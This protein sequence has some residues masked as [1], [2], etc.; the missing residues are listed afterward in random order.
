MKKERKFFTLIE[1][2]VVIAIIAILASMLLP[3]LNQARERA[4]AA[5]CINN[6]KQIT[7]ACII[8]AQDYNGVMT[9][10]HPRNNVYWSNEM[11]DYKYLPASNVFL[12]PNQKYK[13]PYKNNSDALYTYGLNRDIERNVNKKG[14]SAGFYNNILKSRRQAASIT[15]LV[16]DSIRANKQLAIDLGQTCAI[17]SWNNGAEGIASLRHSR[18]G[19]F[20]FVDGSARP[21]GEDKVHGIHP[22]LEEWFLYDAMRVTR[23]PST[24]L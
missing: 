21:I 22:Q 11:V 8:Y 9:S 20:G 13:T 18:K 1:L 24:L 6:L 14:D 15:W 5:Q 2:L 19:N 3:A 4:K 10:A 7:A 17:L 23:G 12:C 16:G